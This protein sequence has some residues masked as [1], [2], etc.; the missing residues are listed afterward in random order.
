MIVSFISVQH[1]ITTFIE[2]VPELLPLNRKVAIQKFEEH[3][4][5]TAD[6][7]ERDLWQAAK[8]YILSKE[9]KPYE[10]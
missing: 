8:R 4:K 9:A 3:M 6:P 2:E 5:N 1:S 10:D 7:A